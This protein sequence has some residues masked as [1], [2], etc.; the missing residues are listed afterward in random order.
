MIKR[1]ANFGGVL[2]A[3][4]TAAAAVTSS[5]QAQGSI[6]LQGYGYPTGQLSSAAAGF[7]GAIAEIDAASPINPAAISTPLRFSI[8]LQFEPEFRR[9]TANE[10]GVSSN[11]MRFPLFMGTGSFNRFTGSLSFS[12]LL[13]RSWSNVYSDSQVVGGTLYPSTLSASS[14]GAMND[15]RFALAYHVNPIVQVGIAYHAITGENRLHFGRSFPDSTGIGSVSQSSS[16][17]YAGNAVSIGT[18]LHPVDGLLI[19]ASV[20]KGGALDVEQ[21]GSNLADADV[22]ARFGASIAWFG[23]PGTTMSLRYEKT[24]WSDMAS[25]GTDSMSTFDATDIGAGLDFSGPTIG[26]TSSVIRLGVR[27]RNLPFGWNGNK[28]DERSYSG[29]VGVPLGRG[30]GHVDLTLQRVMREAGAIKERSWLVT[31]GLGI[32]P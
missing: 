28:V 18:M 6:S 32:R 3:A 17:S 24:A 10:T 1:I 4:L 9:T 12:T 30:R 14:S 21:D 29:G 16:M 19:G 15:V 5:A 25:L 8:Y 26:G 23:I 27:D 11:A 2:V 31:L 7:G 20:R 22:P 13:D